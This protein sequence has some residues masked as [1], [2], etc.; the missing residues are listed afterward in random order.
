MKGMDTGTGRTG[1]L[2]CRS[3]SL[4]EVLTPNGTSLG[5][6]P[7]GGDRRALEGPG[8]NSLLYFSS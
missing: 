5:S 6:V 2:C 4:G 7:T 8:N 3:G 1:W